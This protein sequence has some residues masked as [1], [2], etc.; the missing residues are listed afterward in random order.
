M[1]V[2]LMVQKCTACTLGT[3]PVNQYEIRTLFMYRKFHSEQERTACTIGTV[4]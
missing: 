3:V 1:G 2:L 4:P